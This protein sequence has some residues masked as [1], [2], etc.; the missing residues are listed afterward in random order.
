[1]W[2]FWFS[3]LNIFPQPTVCLPPEGTCLSVNIIS[4]SFIISNNWLYFWCA[5]NNILK[6]YWIASSPPPQQLCS[7]W[8]TVSLQWCCTFLSISYWSSCSSPRES[9]VCQTCLS[10]VSRSCC[11]T[12]TSKCNDNFPC[13]LLNPLWSWIATRYTR[14]LSY[15]S[16]ISQ[17]LI[18]IDHWLTS[19]NPIW[20][21]LVSNWVSKICI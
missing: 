13:T 19:C 11:P 12:I 7:Y 9:L 20:D 10:E 15:L 8:K 3:S 6:R 21:P 5:S 14:C 16:P 4:T 1:M 18:L 17:M 2:I